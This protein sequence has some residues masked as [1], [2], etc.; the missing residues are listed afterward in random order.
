MV[1]LTTVLVSGLINHAL[2]CTE[3]AGRQVEAG[4]MEATL[5]YT[6]EWFELLLKPLRQ[7]GLNFR[8]D[9]LCMR[10]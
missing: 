5:M 1:K 8:S 6:S 9:S 3:F 10:N 2:I 7:A 4:A